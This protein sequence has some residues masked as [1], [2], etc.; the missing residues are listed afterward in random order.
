MFIQK[1][2]PLLGC[3]TGSG[4]LRCCIFSPDW[5]GS[6]L[7]P[8]SCGCSPGFYEWPQAVI[9]WGLVAGWWERCLWLFPSNRDWPRPSLHDFHAGRDAWIERHPRK[10]Q[11]PLCV[12]GSRAVCGMLEIGEHGETFLFPILRIRRLLGCFCGC[13]FCGCCFCPGLLEGSFLLRAHPQRL[14][15]VPHSL[16]KQR[17][18]S[19]SELC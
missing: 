17:M 12:P 10:K 11:T 4:K 6:H 2:K 7:I 14:P 1:N 8:C 18:D 15:P 16:H 5:K 13:C 3:K 19:L 9:F